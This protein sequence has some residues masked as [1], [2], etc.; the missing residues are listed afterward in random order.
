MKHNELRS[1]AHNIA[2]SFVSGMGFLIGVYRTDIF[3]EAR[4][5]PEG[6][7]TVDF[8]NGTST[9]GIA[10]ASLAKAIK[11]YSEALPSLCEKHGLS[12]SSFQVLS[13]KYDALSMHVYITVEDTKGR[14]SIDEYEGMPL[15]HLKTIDSLGRIRT[16]RK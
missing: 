13:V 1:I 16:K 7:I 9:G 4:K 12:A 5:S 14:Q 10:S 6:F 11:L 8:L 3:G 15:K 2:D